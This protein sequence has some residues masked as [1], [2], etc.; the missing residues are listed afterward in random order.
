MG[1]P[2]FAKKVLLLV[3]P[4]MLPTRR[5]MF[6]HRQNIVLGDFHS[7]SEEQAQKLNI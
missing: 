7:Q 4:D 1:K 5:V 2:C 3:A 6:L